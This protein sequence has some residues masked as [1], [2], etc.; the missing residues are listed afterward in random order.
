MISRFCVARFG[1]LFLAA[2][3]YCSQQLGCRNTTETTGQCCRLSVVPGCRYTPETTARCCQWCPAADT[4]L[5]LLDSAVSGFRSSPYRRTFIPLS[6]SLWN[7]LAD[8]VFDGV[9]L[10]DFKSR[11][12]L[13]YWPKLFYPYYSLLLFFN[14]SSFCL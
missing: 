9:E 8:P 2:D 4:H 14:F 13:F 11:P 7:D 10:A 3:Y 6:L 1:V 5:K 12:M